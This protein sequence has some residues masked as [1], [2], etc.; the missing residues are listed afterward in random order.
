VIDRRRLAWHAAVGL[1]VAGSALGLDPVTAAGGASVTDSGWWWRLRPSP[2]VPVPPPPNVDEGQLLVQ[3][4]PEGALALAAI[5]A[6]LPEGQANPVLTLAVADGGDTGGAQAVVLACQA[7]SPWTGGD[8]GAW[9]D[10]PQPACESGV[11]GE[12]S[13]DGATWSFAVAALQFGANLNVV[14]VPGTVE[15]QPAGASGST[16]SLVFEAPGPASI[17]T[18]EGVPPIPPAPDFGAGGLDV[19]A[20]TPSDG[21]SFGVPGPGGSFDVPTG[22]VAALP[23]DEQGLTPVAPVIESQTRLP[24]VAGGDPR[25]EHAQTVGIIVLLAGAAFVWRATQQQPAIAAD[26]TGPLGGLGRFARPRVGTPPSLRG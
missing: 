23:D 5:A 3:G 13:P 16:F 19:P 22:P 10:R 4:A 14:I 7:G 18:A 21:G 17:E 12:R 20:P 9:P 24:I 2:D 1:V 15:G 25:S 8:A 11:V 26:G 6:T